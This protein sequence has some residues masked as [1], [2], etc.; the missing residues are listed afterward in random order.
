MGAKTIIAWADHT[1]NPWI[2]CTRVSEGCRHCYAADLAAN[3]M[4]LDTWGPTADRRI[5]VGVWRDAIQWDREA[6][7]ER[8]RRRVF[9]G[10][11]MDVMDPHPSA[12]TTLPRLWALIRRCQ[13][14][15]WLLLTKRPERY[16]A[17]LPPDWGP[18]GWPHVWLGTSIEDARVAERADH[19]RRLPAVVRWISYEPALGPLDTLDLAGIDWIVY[20]GESGPQF[21]PEG[22]PGDPKAWA[23]AM[24]AR[25]AGAGAAFF[26]KQSAS[27]RTEMGVELDGEVIHQYP[28]PRRAPAIPPFVPG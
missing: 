5:A 24:R 6:T 19:L 8:K 7:A 15:D 17:H 21:R 12:V 3:R 2:G 10:S 9:C 14:L 26:H 20:G 16:A 22:E 13:S 4:G 11:M 25:A 23:R 27:R 28:T 1:A 18:R